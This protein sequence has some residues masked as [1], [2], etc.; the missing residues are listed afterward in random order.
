MKSQ[1]EIPVHI[2]SVRDKVSTGSVVLETWE[3]KERTARAFKALGI[4]WGLAVAAVFLPLLHFFLVPLLL[5]AGPVAFFLVAGQGAVILGGKGECPECRR[6]FNIVRT[7][8]QWPISDSCN[9]CQA[10]LKI[11]RAG[12]A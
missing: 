5:L 12:A 9:H 6:E 11:D 2:T 10:Q 3:K 8:V 1:E 4:S 7:P